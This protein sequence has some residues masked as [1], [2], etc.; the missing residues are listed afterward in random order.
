MRRNNRQIGFYMSEKEFEDFNLAFSHT[1]CRTKSEYARKLLLGKPVTIL[2]R[3]RSLDDFI[4]AAVRIRKQLQ[5]ILEMEIFTP[6]E[7]QTFKTGIDQI[8]Q[9]LIK[10]I[11]QCSQK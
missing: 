10:T 5:A 3:N 7:K 11:E 4:E 9:E 2:Y 6:A 1:L 8:M